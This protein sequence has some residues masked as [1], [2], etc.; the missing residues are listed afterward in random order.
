[1]FTARH[2]LSPCI[3][4]IR[5]VFKRLYHEL[6]NSCTHKPAV[7]VI[8]Q[9]GPSKIKKNVMDFQTLASRGTPSIC[10]CVM[11]S[12]FLLIIPAEW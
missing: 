7:K 11:S 3:S 9:F 6:R 10:G 2:G 1:V 5:F 4:Q 8:I 12:S